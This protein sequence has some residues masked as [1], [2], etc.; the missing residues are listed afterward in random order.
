MRKIKSNEFSSLLDKY[1][2]KLIE[3]NKVPPA[4][5]V[6]VTKFKFLLHLPSISQLSKFSG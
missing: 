1:G 5:H 4:L 6:T 2:L 3:S